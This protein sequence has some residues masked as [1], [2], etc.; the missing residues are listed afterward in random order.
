MFELLIEL[1]ANRFGIFL[2]GVAFIVG[3]VYGWQTFRHD[4]RLYDAA[5]GSEGRTVEARVIDKDQEI[6][7]SSSSKSTTLV[8]YF[9]LSYDTESGRQQVRV[10]VDPDEYAATKEGS[11]IQIRYHPANP[12]YVVTP[13]MERRSVLFASIVTG[14][15]VILGI[16]LVI[17]VIIS[18]FN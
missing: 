15:T 13:K 11:T 12:E 5:T 10:Y 2:L 7:N 3:G 16:L 9:L 1:F 17:A 8:D 4:V 14:F 6:S 18:L